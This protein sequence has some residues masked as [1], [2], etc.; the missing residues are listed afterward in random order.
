MGFGVESTHSLSLGLLGLGRC[1]RSVYDEVRKMAL[2]PPNNFSACVSKNTSAYFCYY[3]RCWYCSQCISNEKRPIPWRILEEFDC[4]Q[5]RVSKMALSEIDKFYDKPIIEI[6][7][8]SALIYRNKV[9]SEF[10]VTQTYRAP[11]VRHRTLLPFN[12]IQHQLSFMIAAA[13][14]QS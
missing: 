5:Y 13:L 2:H 12:P 11:P 14:R 8:S 1:L 6:D 10:M 3:Y 4:K 7:Y 9:L